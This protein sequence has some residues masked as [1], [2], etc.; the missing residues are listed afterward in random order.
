MEKSL[1]DA[2]NG[3]VMAIVLNILAIT[4]SAFHYVHKEI[5]EQNTYLKSCVESN[6]DKPL[7]CFEEKK[8]EWSN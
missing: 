5:S 8:S 7:S 4:F 1:R 2:N 6:L 3:I